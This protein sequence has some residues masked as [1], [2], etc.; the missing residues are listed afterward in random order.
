MAARSLRNIE[1]RKK[2]S[3]RRIARKKISRPQG[4]SPTGRLKLKKQA[5]L[6]NGRDKPAVAASE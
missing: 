3:S 5:G 2:K 1:T 4:N 6:R